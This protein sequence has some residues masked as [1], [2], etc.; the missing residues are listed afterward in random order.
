MSTPRE[1]TNDL[2]QAASGRHTTAGRPHGST[3]LTPHIVVSPAEDALAFYRDVLGATVEDVTEMNGVI[4]HAQLDFGAGKLTLSDPIASY[5]LQ[6]PQADV[7]VTYSL[8]LY[9]PS[10]D[11]VVARAVEHGATLREPVAD[12]VSGD[13]YG[14]ILD[15][16]N[17]RWTIMT[18]VE[19]LSPE[20]SARR[21]AE[22]AAEKAG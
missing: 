13:R 22:W 7:S 18:R 21:V 3:S 10:V 8:A 16:F 2:A 6:A 12:F 4:A 11:E 5:G 14:S 20:E 19:D 17:V 9:V 15:P 1:V